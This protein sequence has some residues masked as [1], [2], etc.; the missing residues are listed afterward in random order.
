V[1]A[2]VLTALANVEQEMNLRFGDPERPLLVSVRSGARASMPGMMDTVLNLGLNDETVEGL[3]A[4]RATRASPTTAI[5]AS[6]RCIP[7]SCWAWSMT[8]SRTSSSDKEDKRLHL[9]TDLSADDWKEVSRL[10]G[11]SSR[12]DRQALPAGSARAALGRHRRGVR[13]WMN[14]RAITYRRCTT[15]PES[16]G[17]AVN[18]QA[19]VFGNMGETARPALPSRAIPRRA[20]TFFYG[21]YPDQRAGRGRRRRHPHAAADHLTIAAREGRVRLS[22]EEAM[23]E[24]YA[25]SSRRGAARAHYRD[26]QDIEF[27]VQQGKL[28]MLQTRNGKRTAKA[29]SASRS[30]WRARG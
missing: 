6:S 22:L 26:M 15:S 25:S 10:Q 23:P 12:S 17:T 7:T 13:S 14:Q 3:A 18:V 11:R 30:T 9:D 19:M 16:W 24:A 20:R 29:A 1:R 28:W 8:R 4:A 21:E 2:D 5:A 27:T